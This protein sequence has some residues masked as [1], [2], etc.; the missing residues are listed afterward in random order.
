MKPPRQCFELP[1]R[2]TI[3]ASDCFGTQQSILS[4]RIM[5]KHR[6]TL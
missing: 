5:E 2:H 6:P 3:F 4:F 1:R